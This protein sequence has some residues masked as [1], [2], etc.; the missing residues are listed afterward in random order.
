MLFRRSLDGNGHNCGQLST[1]PYPQGAG[2]A[3]LAIDLY[4][5]RDH[6]ALCQ[7]GSNPLDRFVFSQVN[8]APDIHPIQTRVKGLNSRD[9][10]F[11]LPPALSSILQSV[12]PSH[13]V[14]D[15]CHQSSTVGIRFLL[16]LCVI[17]SK[18]RCPSTA[19][20]VCTHWSV[21]RPPALRDCTLSP[22]SPG[23]HHG[24]ATDGSSS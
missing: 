11:S 6:C 16:I 3:D 1:R 10:A 14:S 18:V 5:S 17:V 4:G 23:P 22:L 2:E 19:F 9:G 8:P 21:Q 12:D 15:L 7:H 20:P 13:Q 24:V